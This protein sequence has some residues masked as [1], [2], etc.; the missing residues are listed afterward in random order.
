MATRTID[1]VNLTFAQWIR[2]VDIAVSK[3]VGCSVYDL[4]DC[5]FRDWFEDGM[6]PTEAATEALEN[7][8]LDEDADDLAEMMEEVWD[9]F[10]RDACE[11]EGMY[12]G[13]YELYER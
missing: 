2:K 12:D 4:A 13:A 9:Y 10:P 8:G 3:R 7:E 1:P 6:T 11:Q 5:P